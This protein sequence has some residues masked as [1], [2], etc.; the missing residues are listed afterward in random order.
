[1]HANFPVHSLSLFRRC[2][3]AGADRPNGLIGHNHARKPLSPEQ[4]N[5]MIQLRTNDC[6]GFASLTLRERLSHTQNRRQAGIQRS[7]YLCSNHGISFAK[8]ATPLGMPDDDPRATKIE[9]HR[10]A[11]LTGIRPILECAE[12]LPANRNP[13]ALY[14]RHSLG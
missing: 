11:H 12:I 2:R 5:H 6:L 7:L 4:I 13:S 9:E 14:G 10:G 8:Q 1:M 3:L